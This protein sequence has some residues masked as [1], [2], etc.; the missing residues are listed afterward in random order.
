M[1]TIFNSWWGNKSYRC[2][3]L[4][5]QNILTAINISSMFKLFT[6]VI[7]VSLVLSS[8]IVYASAGDPSSRGVQPI[9]V[10]GN[11]T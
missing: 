3:T 11:N 9:F 2:S 5:S 10:E 7:A 1:K 6:W 4:C 8:Q